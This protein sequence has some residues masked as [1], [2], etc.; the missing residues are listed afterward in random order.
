MYPPPHLER[1][2]RGIKDSALLPALCS[3]LLFQ[4]RHLATGGALAVSFFLIFF[5]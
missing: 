2:V 1:L 4:Q 3:Q 5:I